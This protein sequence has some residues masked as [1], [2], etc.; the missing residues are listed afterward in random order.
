MK[1]LP[2]TTNC[3]CAKCTNFSSNKDSV[4][5]FNYT[6]GNVDVFVKSKNG[7]VVERV[8]KE[9]SENPTKFEKESFYDNGKIRSHYF[10]E[11]T[12]GVPD[13]VLRMYN[14]NSDR[15]HDSEELDPEDL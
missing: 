15:I 9:H 14:E 1:I 12:E 8:R 3:H 5:N 13:S 6:D 7:V 4:Q 2:V 11:E 10:E